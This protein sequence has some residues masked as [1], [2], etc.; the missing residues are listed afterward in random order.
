MNLFLYFC[1]LIWISMNFWQVLMYTIPAL[2][3]LLSVWIVMHKLFKDEEQKRLWELKKASQKEIS[4]TRLRAYERLAL[5]LERTQPEA[6][7]MGL[8]ERLE[9]AGESLANLSVTKMQ[10]ELLRTVR[11]EF[12]HNLSQQ[13]YVSDE[14]WAKI[15]GARDE[16]AAFI[17]T[18]AIHMPKESTSMDYAKVLMTAYRNNGETPH[19]IALDALKEEARGLL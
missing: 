1:A 12:D 9:A 10:Q 7:V 11:L 5:V 2:V 18:M 16:M 13:V 17:S 8:N 15:I 3:V 4:P 19:Q 14:T 6:L